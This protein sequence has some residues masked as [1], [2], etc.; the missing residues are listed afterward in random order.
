M[1]GPCQPS[2]FTSE[3]LAPDL[4]AERGKEAVSSYSIGAAFGGAGTL[5][6]RAQVTPLVAAGRLAADLAARAIQ[7]CPAPAQ[8]A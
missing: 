4:A 2:R 7:P 8:Q 6:Q 3:E 1:A 5:E